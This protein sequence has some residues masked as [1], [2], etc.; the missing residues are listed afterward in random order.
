[1]KKGIDISEWQ[2]SVD[3]S[4]LKEQGI[5]FAIIRCGYGRAS[6]QKDKM[7]EK[8]YEGLKKAGIKIGCYL[9]SYANKIADGT[10]EAQNCLDFIKGKTFDLPI[11]YDLEDKTTSVL[12]KNNITVLATNFCKKIKVSGYEVGIYANLNWWKNYINLGE[13]KKE[14]SDLKVWLAQWEV[15]KPTANFNY[16]FWQYTSSG[17]LEG[18]AGRVDMN[19]MCT[20][21]VDKPVENVDNSKKSNEEIAKEV[22]QGKWGNGQERVDKL[23]KAGYDYTEIQK[24]VNNTKSDDKTIKVGDKVQVINAI[25]YNGQPFAKYYDSYNVIEVKGDRV[26]IGRGATVTC[27]INVKNL[28][29]IL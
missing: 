13:I 1:M 3:Y 9:Y 16:D 23:T 14:I 6:T 5:E 20:E 10:L 17:V 22:W 15:S 25:Q 7:F 12:G 11:F 26:V 28:R 29:K 19:Y 27:A 2:T 21:A 24:I 8:H 4:K 18:I